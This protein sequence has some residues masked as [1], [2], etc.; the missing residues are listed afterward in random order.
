[1]CVGD[2]DCCTSSHQCSLGEGDCD[3]YGDCAGELVCG[4]DNCGAIRDMVLAE[5][6][7]GTPYR[8]TYENSKFSG[9]DDCCWYDSELAEFAEA[10][11]D[12]KN[13][14]GQAAFE[15][16]MNKRMRQFQG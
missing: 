4:N 7:P 5:L 1:M 14:M 9:T 3:G 10:M 16:E 8:A 15:R 13:K 11:I 6:P 2:N 12:K